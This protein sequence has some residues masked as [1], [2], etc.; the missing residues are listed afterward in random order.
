MRDAIAHVNEVLSHLEERL[1]PVMRKGPGEQKPGDLQMIKEVGTVSDE[2]EM[3]IS[4][5][6]HVTAIHGL[7]LRVNAILSRLDV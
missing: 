7:A 5:R 4:M 6:M 2:S 1:G 3:L